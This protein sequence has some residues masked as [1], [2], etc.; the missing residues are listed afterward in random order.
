MGR[1]K[2]A[3]IWITLLSLVLKIMGFLRESAVAWKFGASD[4]TN[5][6]FLAFAFVTLTITM[7]ANGFNAVFLPE[8]LKHRRRNED[9]TA[10]A[11]HDASGI[12]NYTFLLFVGLSI[13][14][15]VSA[16][17]F[18]PLI[19]P[20][21]SA[22]ESE[23]AIE[24]TKVFLLFMSVIALS[25]MLESYLQALRIFVPTQ[26]SKLSGTLFAVV[27]IFIFGDAWGIYSVAYGFVFGTFLGACIQFYYLIRG[28]FTWRPVLKMDKRFLKAF[29]LLLLPAL[30]HSSVGHVNVFVD[31]AFAAGL[32]GAAVTYLNNASLLMSI[33]S[34][35]FA[36]TFVAII[37][38]LLSER[39]DDQKQFQN[40]LFLGYQMGVM[41]LLPIAVGVFL[42]GESILSFI[43]ERGA[44]TAEDTAAVYDA[45]KFYVPIIVTQGL[46]TISV[47]AMYANGNAKKILMVSSTTIIVNVLLNALLIGPLGYPGLALSSAGVSVYYFIG[48]TLVL[49][50]GYEKSE[51]LKLVAMFGR[52]LI[53]TA[54]MGAVVLLLEQWAMLDALYSLW[55]LAI[56]VPIAGVVYAGATYVFYKEG[57]RRMI[58]LLAKRGSAN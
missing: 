17:W 32:S 52:V 24:I 21:M 7:V 42:V 38:T 28:G 39:A 16:S 22:T 2:Q 53:P 30:L 15:Y 34:T 46:L 40:T 35:I 57:F 44:F 8:Y 50:R 54:L 14:L 10:K 6:F 13:I 58:Q 20:G 36:T 5:G 37:F 33:P 48:I 26:V 31:K 1:L 4:V 23:I 3:A 27:F 51:F 41:V 43:Y 25:G 49:Y 18:V 29:L 55:K 45:L 47:K 9:N 19:Y 11:E 56:I 12:M